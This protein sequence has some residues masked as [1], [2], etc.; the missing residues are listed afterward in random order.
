MKANRLSDVGHLDRAVADVVMRGHFLLVAARRSV[1][2]SGR[3]IQATDG[4]DGALHRRSAG[5]TSERAK[6]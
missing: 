1:E 3:R 6:A 5:I 2:R 4:T